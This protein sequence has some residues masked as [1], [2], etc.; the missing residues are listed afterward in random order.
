MFRFLLSPRWIGLAVFAALMAVLCVWLGGWQHDRWENRK[1]TNAVVRTNL[2]APAV[3]VSEAVADGWSDDLEW[4]TVTATG[5][6]EP[7]HEVTVRFAHRDGRPGVQVITPLRQA[8][9]SVVLVDRGWVEG[10]NTGEAPDDVPPAPAGTVTVTGWLQPDSTAD[11]EATT[12][13]DGQVR[14]VR[15][16]SWTD[17]LGA[18][19]LAGHITQTQDVP[20]GLLGPQDP[21]LGTGPHFFYALQWYFFAGLAVFGYVW[22]VRTEMLERRQA[23]ATRSA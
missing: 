7:A 5:T 6:F 1:A 3:P 11:R 9:G 17:L 4:R 14:A 10:P 23:K 15:G 2:D 18:A 22:F 19:P 13:T 8:D 16:D 21:D 12:P 20:E